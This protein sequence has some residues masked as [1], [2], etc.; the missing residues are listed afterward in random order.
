M[1]DQLPGSLTS[2]T[3]NRLRE[4]KTQTFYHSLKRGAPPQHFF[5]PSPTTNSL[6]RSRLAFILPFF[7]SQINII[8]NLN[9]R[10]HQLIHV[11]TIKWPFSVGEQ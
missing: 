11:N 3:M 8:Y 5:P 2:D 1:D 10:S 7:P 4:G 6:R 9:E